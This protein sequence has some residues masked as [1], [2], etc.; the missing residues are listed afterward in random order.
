MNFNIKNESESKKPTPKIYKNF[1][2]KHLD[3]NN[4]ETQTSN[5]NCFKMSNLNDNYGKIGDDKIKSY[6]LGKDTSRTL[7]QSNTKLT[8]NENNKSK[9]KLIVS[10]T[11]FL[12]MPKLTINNNVINN[13]TVIN[14]NSVNTKTII[15]YNKTHVNNDNNIVT[16]PKKNE[17]Y[18]NF[19][20]LNQK[21]TRNL[22]N[23]IIAGRNNQFITKTLNTLDLGKEIFSSKSKFPVSNFPSTSVITQ[24]IR[25]DSSLAK[26]NPSLTT[27]AVPLIKNLMIEK[28]FQTID[29]N[30]QVNAN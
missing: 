5:L 20:N 16:I 29:N 27:R 13:I 12:S 30:N 3:L 26:N 15:N 28:N 22:K 9:D 8:G 7:S 6:T 25:N 23:N 17:F 19:N 1:K 24:T 2:I 14:N 4:Q 11:K 10:H 18:V 21:N